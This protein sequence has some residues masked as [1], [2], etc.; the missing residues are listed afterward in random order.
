[1]Y[2]YIQASSSRTYDS[3]LVQREMHRLGTL[4]HTHLPSIGLAPSISNAPSSSASHANL[5]APSQSGLLSSSAQNENP[6]AALHVHVL[7]L[8]NG[9]PLRVPMYVTLV[10]LIEVRLIKK[11]DRR[12]ARISTS[13]S[14]D[15][16]RW[17]SAPCRPKRS[18]GSRTIRRNF[19]PVAW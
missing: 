19:S 1:M 9:E 13:W 18:Q 8:F 4:A 10:L 6:W 2:S 15:T 5:V 16:S 12:S 17:S 3:K 7:P 11:R 14:S